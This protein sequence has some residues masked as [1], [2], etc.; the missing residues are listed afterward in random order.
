MVQQHSCDPTTVF[1][2][3]YVNSLYVCVLV[4]LCLIKMLKVLE[5]C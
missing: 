5:G 4:G 2:V 3:D 1:V